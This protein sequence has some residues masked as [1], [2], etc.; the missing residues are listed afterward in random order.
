[1][2]GNRVITFDA[3]GEHLA[4]GGSED[5]DVWTSI[6]RRRG[7]TIAAE[8]R[9]DT[10][11]LTFSNDGKRLIASEIYGGI[12]SW[13][14][15]GPQPIEESRGQEGHLGAVTRLVFPPTVALLSPPALK[16]RRCEL[17]ILPDRSQVRKDDPIAPEGTSLT[18]TQLRGPGMAVSSLQLVQCP[19]AMSSL[20]D[21]VRNDEGSVLIFD[22]T[23]SRQ[24]AG[25]DRVLKAPWLSRHAAGNA[26]AVSTPDGYVT[27]WDL[28]SPSQPRARGFSRFGSIARPAAPLP[29]D[30]GVPIDVPWLPPGAKLAPTPDLAP[31][32]IMFSPDG[33]R[34]SAL[35]LGEVLLWDL[36]KTEPQLSARL[37]EQRL[38]PQNPPA[39]DR[40]VSAAETANAESS[41]R[42]VTRA[43]LSARATCSLWST[44]RGDHPL[45][46]H[47]R[48][49][50]SGRR[51]RTFAEDS[52]SDF[53]R[54]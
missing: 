39:P 37:D 11:G 23:V 26:V 1:L 15:S 40:L 42:E 8:I 47:S 32:T 52:G 31:T 5:I 7:G 46:F 30:A 41:A 38:K 14:L 53:Y 35:R 24:S 13:D 43:S 6:P 25:R 51:S 17:G 34:L 36:S 3:R 12:R 19:Y 49:Q 33:R 9:G 54:E 28:R 21:S 50:S 20:L 45:T 16:T 44:T 18:F 48:N 27:A 2:L 4:V 10:S 22:I 29:L